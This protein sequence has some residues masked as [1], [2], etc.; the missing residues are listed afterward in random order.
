ML[1]LKHKSK[2]RIVTAI[3]L[4]LLF[5]LMSLYA[6]DQNGQ[7]FNA[8]YA[9]NGGGWACAAAVA[10]CVG[11]T[12]AAIATCSSGWFSWGCLSATALAA[13][14]CLDVPNKC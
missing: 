13:A 5:T 9:Q 2:K 12:A 11:L 7:D 8:A 4:L 1:R 3:C 6:T 10:K 14:A